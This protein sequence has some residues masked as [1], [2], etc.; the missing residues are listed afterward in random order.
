MDDIKEEIRQLRSDIKSD[1]N[2]VYDKIDKRF[3]KVE[4]RFLRIETK[5][6]GIVVI[7]SATVQGAG[8]FIKAKFFGG[9]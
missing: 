3:D 2:R 9:Q 8:Q 6:M 1:I 7:L 5:V 4:S